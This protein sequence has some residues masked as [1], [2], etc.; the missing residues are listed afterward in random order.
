MPL[1]KQKLLV[2]LCF[3]F[4][5]LEFMSYKDKKEKKNRLNKWNMSD[6]QIPENLLIYSAFYISSSAN[7]N[8]IIISKRFYVQD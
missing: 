6:T 4:G 5:I 1:P 8:K 7:N 3:S 2:E